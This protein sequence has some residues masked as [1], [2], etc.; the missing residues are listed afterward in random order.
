[1]V[2]TEWRATD[3]AWWWV[4]SILSGFATLALAV[5]PGLGRRHEPLWALAPAVVLVL[6]SVLAG[7]RSRVRLT[8]A[9]VEVR[10]LR[11]RTYRWADIASVEVSPDWDGTG[12]IWLRERGAL[13]T[14][15]PEVIGLPG[16]RPQDAR[17]LPV[18]RVVE[19]IRERAVR[20]G[21]LTD[22][23]SGP[24]RQSSS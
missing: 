13:P 22:P 11:T 9:G 6:L 2:R 14:T 15:A 17:E 20:A 10:R 21:G 5:L 12:S 4:W 1:M 18:E 8:D 7:G 19:L 24:W 3:D 16:R 23:A